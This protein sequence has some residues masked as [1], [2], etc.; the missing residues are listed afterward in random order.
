MHSAALS[1]SALALRLIM[2]LPPP[3]R[4]GQV[5]HPHAPDV[6]SFTVA[7]LTASQPY[8]PPRPSITAATPS[9]LGYNTIGAPR[10]TF[11]NADWEYVYPTATAAP[12]IRSQDG[13]T[14]LASR[15]HPFLKR[16]MLPDI[17]HYRTL[18]THSIA[19]L[20]SRAGRYTMLER[21][22]AGNTTTSAALLTLREHLFAIDL[23]LENMRRVDNLLT[24]VDREMIEDFT[25]VAQVCRPVFL[26]P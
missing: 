14:N 4:Q 24:L 6:N 17:L 16:T 21:C 13:P 23:M 5:V 15:L 20:E 11:T 22:N 9:E 3:F 2:A 12:D 26:F 25:Q 18:R 10:S 1:A 19:Q 7:A 8:H